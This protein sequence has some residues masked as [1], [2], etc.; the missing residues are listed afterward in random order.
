[1]TSGTYVFTHVSK[2][3]SGSE[4]VDRNTCSAATGTSVGTSSCVSQEISISA[5]GSFTRILWGGEASGVVNGSFTKGWSSC[6][7]RS[8]NHSC[9]PIQVS[10]YRTINWPV[11]EN[12]SRIGWT[13]LT[14]TTT[15]RLT[16]A[17]NSRT[18]SLAGKCNRAGGSYVL[19]G[20]PQGFFHSCN[21]LEN[22]ITFEDYGYWP[23]ADMA[24]SLDCRL[25]G[26]PK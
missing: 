3:S 16:H 5:T 6:Q 9:Q 2:A 15:S 18:S 19:T 23:A 12:R 13:T 17:S 20:R 11:T 22:K 26:E 24:V 7:T 21:N 4:C 25:T 10:G 1:M 8:Q 14:D